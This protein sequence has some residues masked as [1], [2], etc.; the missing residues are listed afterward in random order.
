MTLNYKIVDDFLPE[1]FFYL[2]YNNILDHKRS[3]TWHY[4]SSVSQE[5]SSDGCYFVH[6]FYGDPFLWPGGNENFRNGISQFFYEFISPT[7]NYMMSTGDEWELKSLMRCKSNLYPQTD[8]IKEHDWHSDR[9]FSHKGSILYLNTNNG[10]TILEDGTK[11]ESIANRMLFFDP[12]I[13]HK[14][15]TC[16]DKSCRLN[17]NFNYF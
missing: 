11:I 2:L 1:A 4:L 12:S 8:K 3:F 16:T 15:T 6:I 17:I 5:Q 9:E 7:I 13:K 10:Y 14:S